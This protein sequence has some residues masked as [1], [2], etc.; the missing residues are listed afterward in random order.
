M[1][2]NFLDQFYTLDSETGNYI[3]EIALKD[4]DDIFNSWDSSVYNIRDLDSSLKS[5]LEECSF[6]ITSS[7]DIVL[8]FN[9][10]NQVKDEEREKKI[11]RGIRN[12]FNYCLYITKTKFSYR[13]K[14]SFYYIIASFLFTVVSYYLQNIVENEFFNQIVLLGLTVGGWVFL[15]EA[16]SL[17]FIHSSDLTRKKKQ[18]KRILSAPMWFRYDD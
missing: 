15:W 8:R 6:D 13:R 2:R 7:K 18:Y 3:I 16:F 14:R 11:E 12:Y 9:I 1:N 17:L 4:Y 5:F 10:K